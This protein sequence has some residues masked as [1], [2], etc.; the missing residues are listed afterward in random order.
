MGLS[1]SPRIVT[2]GLVMCLDAGNS[3]SYPGTGTVWTDLAGNIGT[4]TN[5]PTFNSENGGSVVFDGTNDGVDVSGTESFNGP[6]GVSYTLS[7]WFYPTRTGAWQGVVCKNRSTN[8]YTA[9]F[10]SDDNKFALGNRSKWAMH[11]INYKRTL[12]T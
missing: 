4:L 10:L 1:H 2:D 8:T 3:R 7:A 9:L 12:P 6:L 11:Q 5:G